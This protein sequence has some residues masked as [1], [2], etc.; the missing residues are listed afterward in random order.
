ME[1]P[2]VASS[3]ITSPPNVAEA[4]VTELIAAGVRHIIYVPGGP[5]MPFLSAA[6][7]RSCFEFVLSRHEAGAAF[8]AE[9]LARATRT[10]ALA[11]VTAGPGVTNAVTPVY[12]AYREMTPLFLLSAQVSRATLGKGAAQ[13]LE[14]ASLLQTITKRSETLPDGRTAR[15]RVRE[16]LA[17]TTRGRPGPVHL[18]IPADVWKEV[19]L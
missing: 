12:V 11:A 1:S 16:L 6:F 14:T 8:I 13:E 3:P 5:L 10:V 7:R 19:T 17:L 4:L 18:S 9:G 15:G 2:R